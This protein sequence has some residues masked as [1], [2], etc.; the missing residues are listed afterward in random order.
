M[1]T[2]WR[3]YRLAAFLF[4]VAAPAWPQTETL[5]CSVDALNRVVAVNPDGTFSL[6]NVPADQRVT[7]VRAVCRQ[8]DSTL[9]GRSE[10][11]IVPPGGQ[12]DVGEIQL[13]PIPPALQGLLLFAVPD[14]MTALGA[15]AQIFPVGITADGSS[16][17]PED[18]TSGMSFTA[19]NPAIC[20]VD[21][22]GVVTATGSG[23]CFVTGISQ[24]VVA[25][26]PLTIELGL[27]ADADGL[28]DDFESAYPCLDPDAADA[29]ADRDSD[30]RTSLQELQS[31]TDPCVADTDGDGLNDGQET[32]VGSNPVL[33]DSDLDSLLDGQEPNPTGNGD[34]DGLINVLDPDQDN[35]GLP[36][37]IEVRICGNPTCATPTADNDGDG[38]SNL[39]EVGLGTDP[40][41]A[42]TDGDGLSDSAEVLGGTDPV[43]PDMDGDGFP[44]GFETALGSD[45][46]NPNSRPTPPPITQAVGA[47][48]SVLNAAPPAPPSSAEAAGRI[49][50]VLNAA[51]LAE[52]ISAE[53]SG[54]IFSLLNSALPPT[55]ASAESLGRLFSVQNTVP[56]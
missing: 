52:P 20:T 18:G 21:P 14:R 28:P 6:D 24:G 34:G 3:P 46:K 12:V 54:R 27:D 47:T 22:A 2:R 9:G 15:T 53:V 36:D 55:P 50:S 29:G 32:A 31:G 19:S 38:L 11:L 10:F 37:G 30:G 26:V 45:P 7:R 1:R 25:T 23:T 43:N 35:D 16:V 48:F 39:D 44:D 42:D 5:S 33:P 17:P 40:A 56:P 13:S 51:P 8:G 4:A 49:V 41:R